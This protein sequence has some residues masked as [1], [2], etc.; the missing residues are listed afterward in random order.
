MPYDSPVSPYT[1]DN[2][3]NVPHAA[4]NTPASAVV[5]KEFHGGSNI[6]GGGD[7]E[8]IHPHHVEATHRLLGHHSDAEEKRISF[9]E[10]GSLNSSRHQR[11]FLQY[12]QQQSQVPASRLL[13]LN[14]STGQSDQ[15]SRY[16]YT[17]RL[18]DTQ[19]SLSPPVGTECN[20][21]YQ[22][23]A[24]AVSP[25]TGYISYSVEK[26]DADEDRKMPS[27]V[28]GGASDV[29]KPVYP[30]MVD[31]RH[32]ARNRQNQQT[33]QSGNGQQLLH[34]LG[35]QPAKRA[36]TAY[37]SAQLVEL[38]KEFHFNRYLCRPRR[39][40]MAAL[41][42][43][44]ERQIK[45][46]F[47]NRRMKYKKEQKAKGFFNVHTEK[48]IPSP[49]SATESP[50][51][52]SPTSP[53][54]S[55]VKSN[56]NSVPGGSIDYHSGPGHSPSFTLSQRGSPNVSSGEDQMSVGPHSEMQITSS[57]HHQLDLPEKPSCNPSL[58]QFHPARQQS[59]NLHRNPHPPLPSTESEG[60]F[61]HRHIHQENQ[62]SGDQQEDVDRKPF[63]LNVSSTPPVIQ[64]TLS[65]S[66]ASPS[67]SASA[68]FT[69]QQSGSHS[70]ET[71][72]LSTHSNH[73][74]RSSSISSASIGARPI[75][76]HADE[77]D[78]LGGSPQ[79]PPNTGQSSVGGFL[80]A[81]IDF[82]PNSVRAMNAAVSSN[83]FQSPLHHGSYYYHHPHAQHLSPQMSH[84]WLVSTQGTEITQ[85]YMPTASPPK[86]T[87]L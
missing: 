49:T 72:N 67:P 15:T 17:G 68:S 46:W 37:T 87:H 34:H 23:G 44:T 82:T 51:T 53:T 66:S 63:S 29:F 12:Y 45:I 43:L 50:L 3:N 60:F 42:N 74:Y 28:G 7:T 62:S 5:P 80:S 69:R 59:F 71:E 9:S 77:W 70:Q 55:S 61:S 85:K 78:P 4:A 19:T 81:A 18:H 30:W 76:P 25:F 10:D 1:N 31:S 26:R 20:P 38:E 36:R 33:P 40:E 64:Q 65:S 56:M 35:E 16:S 21:C 47:Q 83:P 27:Y 54:V 73:P 75:F 41:L 6:V 8:D 48:N 22:Q 14:T 2:N 52:Q 79:N 86:L 11:L 39:I 84:E 57:R 58:F 24:S 13:P 32:N